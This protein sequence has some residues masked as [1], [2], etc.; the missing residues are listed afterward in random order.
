MIKRI[1]RF[2]FVL[3]LSTSLLQGAE[4][5][6]ASLER[7]FSMH[8]ETLRHTEIKQ[9]PLVICFSGTPGMGKSY[10]AKL[11]EE[12]YQGV[13]ISTDDIRHI[14]RQM[15]TSLKVESTVDTYFGYFSEHYKA[16]NQ[17]LI[18]DASIDR[19]YKR[20]FPYFEERKIPYVVIRLEVSAED[21]LDRVS[22]REG[23]NKANYIKHMASW[24][25]DYE[26]FLDAFSNVFTIKNGKAD[27]LDLD[28]LYNHINAYIP[29]QA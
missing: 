19:R 12:K 29:K 1:Y 17:L 2:W 27:Q 7:L 14:V 20:L 23:E 21:A 25:A 10:V 15:D 5:D 8:C 18:I 6:Q 11:I 24:R 22:E 28:A 9:P 26:A 3:A 13:R 16:P 4:V